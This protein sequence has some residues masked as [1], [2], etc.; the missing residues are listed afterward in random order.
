MNLISSPSNGGVSAV[1]SL[2]SFTNTFNLNMFRRRQT[3]EAPLPTSKLSKGR[4]SGDNQ[5]ATGVSTL[6]SVESDPESVTEVIP[7]EAASSNP[8]QA[9]ELLRRFE[10]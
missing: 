2:A 9:T 7:E 10:N 4:K 3:A 6:S 8:T 5:N 1:S